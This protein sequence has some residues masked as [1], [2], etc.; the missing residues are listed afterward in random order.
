MSGIIKKTKLYLYFLQK[1]ATFLEV[2]RFELVKHILLIHYLADE[3]RTVFNK[4]HIN[5]L[6][7]ELN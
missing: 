6:T 7:E 5:I 2:T 4:D 1:T 3:S